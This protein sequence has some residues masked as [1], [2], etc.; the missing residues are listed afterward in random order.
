MTTTTPLPGRSAPD[1]PTHDGET[2]LQERAGVRQRSE[3]VMRRAVRDFM[4]DQHRA[5]FAALPFL[6]VG[7]LDRDDRP[8]AS[9]LTGRPGFLSSPDPRTLTIRAV[10]AFGDPLGDALVVGAPLG[11]LGLQPETR[12]RNRMNGTVAGIDDGLVTVRVGQSFGNCPQYIQARA[13]RFVAE[14]GDVAAPRPVHRGGRLLSGRDR[15][16]VERADTFFIATAAPGARGGDPVRGVDVSHRGGRPGFVQVA[17]QDG[18][19]VLTVPDFLGNFF[20][21]TLGNIAINPAAGLLFVDFASGDALMLSGDA[22]VVWDGP[23]VAAFA[24][25]ER[26][27]R[28]RLRESLRIE[29]AVPLRWSEPEPSPQLHATGTWDEAA[30]V[31]SAGRSAGDRPFRVTGIVDE[32]ETARSFHLQ[33]ADGG[34]V[35]PYRPGQFLPVALDIDGA[36][37]PVRRTYTLSD[38]P[39]GLGYRITVK[40]EPGGAASTWLHDRLRVGD[41]IRAGR[42][43]GGFVLDTDSRRP[44]LLL[45]AGIGVTPMIAMLNHLLGGPEG[46]RRAPHRRIRFAHVARHGGE[47]AFADHVRALARAHPDHLTVHVRYTAPRPADAPGRDFDG[48]GRIDRAALGA[49]LP[50]DDCDVYLCGPA[51]F[52][53]DMRE[54]LAGLGV[55]PE[56]IRSEAFGPAGP[57]APGPTILG[58][59]VDSA[60]VT[61]RA[62]GITVA[63]TPE[64]GSLLD[65]AEAHGVDAPA[66]C[67]SGS[68]GTCAASLTR[69]ATRYLRAPVAEPAAGRILLCQAVPAGRA[70]ELAP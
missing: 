38:A 5:F 67:R 51:G 31:L 70:I 37:R 53:A 49:W 13:P 46:R 56:R 66:G 30:S 42:P 19:T 15:A 63:W 59:A 48:T 41:S 44:V 11:L 52:M 55:P 65:L 58:P 14:P 3:A 22:E 69:G 33:P 50:P 36:R 60:D 24:G 25:A 47:H 26:L 8:W 34:A 12:R 32:S 57:V 23:E 27:M 10:P 9:I 16:L 21:N 18:V 45:S 64:A 61:F 6:V 68:C 1:R 54:A 35:A 29:A 4:P 43:A 62:A 2:A 17:A 20:F 28:F 7:S 39:G 40:R